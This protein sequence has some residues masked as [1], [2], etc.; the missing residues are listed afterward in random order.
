MDEKNVLKLKEA[1]QKICEL[2]ENNDEEFRENT[3][4]LVSWGEYPSAHRKN[5]G[6]YKGC[7]RKYSDI[8][9]ENAVDGIY[10][11][12]TENNI[13]QSYDEFERLHDT[14][15]STS[16]Q[17]MAKGIYEAFNALQIGFGILPDSNL[18]RKGFSRLAECV[19]L[20]YMYNPKIIN[21]ISPAECYNYFSNITYGD[22]LYSNYPKDIILNQFLIRL[23]NHIKKE[24]NNNGILN[25]YK[26]YVFFVVLYE[27]FDDRTELKEFHRGEKKSTEILK[28]N[29]SKKA[30]AFIKEVSDIDLWK[31]L[32]EHKNQFSAFRATLRNKAKK[33]LEHKDFQFREYCGMVIHLLGQSETY[34]EA[35]YRKLIDKTMPSVDRPLKRYDFLSCLIFNCISKL[36][37]AKRKHLS[38]ILNINRTFAFAEK[39][40]DEIFFV[41]VC[42]INNP[43]SAL[44]R[45][46]IVAIFYYYCELCIDAD[47]ELILEKV[48]LDSI[49]EISMEARNN[50][51]IFAIEGKTK[52]FEIKKINVKKYRTFIDN[53]RSQITPFSA[54]T[55][56]KKRWITKELTSHEKLIGQKIMETL[57]YFIIE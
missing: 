17:G 18:A 52:S 50:V 22:N 32:L 25:I 49:S 43:L 19:F 7:A 8:L 6:S 56:N 45:K 30:S 5:E 38:K 47:E 16:K 29:D 13:Q 36:Y 10:E 37:D 51:I 27:N 33:I 40:C 48:C 3:I 42:D 39:T 12:L 1:M 55:E 44:Y 46:V 11:K 15:P 14:P 31:Y 35:L 4:E 20:V 23:E 53:I 9:R 28:T 41:S 24:G 57:Y 21:H 34:G 26:K 2:I 54:C